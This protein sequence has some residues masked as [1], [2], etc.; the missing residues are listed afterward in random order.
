MLHLGCQAAVSEPAEI[1]TVSIKEARGMSMGEPVRVSG[2]VTVQ[3]HAFASSMS[4]GFAVQDE[5]AGI[6]V[7][8]SN[9][10]FELGDRVKAT[11]KEAR[12]SVS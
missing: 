11:G 1:E 2:T 7:L 3:S 10:A 6:Y 9:H 8:D 5:S 4:S 12:S